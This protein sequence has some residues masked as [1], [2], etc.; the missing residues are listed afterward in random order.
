MHKIQK[1]THATAANTIDAK[2]S[3]D[4]AA[5]KVAK[6]EQVLAES[7]TRADAQRNRIEA[8]GEK[9]HVLMNGKFGHVL[10]QN[11]S[12]L[13]DVANRTKSKKDIAAADEADSVYADHI[14]NQPAVDGG[15]V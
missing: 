1:N 5:K 13:R 8:T 3:A 11:A 15:K 4:S 7:T 6:V 14:N 2:E 10:K 12:L 9:T